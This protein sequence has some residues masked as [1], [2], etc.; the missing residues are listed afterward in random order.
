M[1]VGDHDKNFEL[2][3][4]EAESQDHKIN[5]ELLEFQM[6]EMYKYDDEY[7]DN[8]NDLKVELI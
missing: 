8:R 6:E 4:I 1:K 7:L 5:F 2:R 3:L